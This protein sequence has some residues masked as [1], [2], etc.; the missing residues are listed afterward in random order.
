MQNA[1]FVIV[2]G[3]SFS[4]LHYVFMI[5]CTVIVI[6]FTLRDLVKARYIE[7]NSTRLNVYIHRVALFQIG[8]NHP[9]FLHASSKIIATDYSISKKKSCPIWM[10]LLSNHTF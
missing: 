4:L 6:K 5:N 2:I 7:A 1:G 9:E 8:A 10:I 3:Y